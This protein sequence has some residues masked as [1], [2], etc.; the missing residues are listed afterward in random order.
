MTNGAAGLPRA[1]VLSS[2]N[3]IRK[4]VCLAIWRASRSMPPWS[5]LPAGAISLRG[6]PRLPYGGYVVQ[7]L[8]VGEW[9]VDPG[10]I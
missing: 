9:V 7:R 8:D 6:A 1:N 4:E 5:I 3:F 2:R 10:L